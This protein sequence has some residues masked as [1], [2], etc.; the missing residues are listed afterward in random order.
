MFNEGINNIPEG[1]EKVQKANNIQDFQ[2]AIGYI[3]DYLLR[4]KY[5]VR[6]IHEVEGRAYFQPNEYSERDMKL[7]LEEA[8]RKVIDYFNNGIHK[9]FSTIN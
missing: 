4:R 6:Y 5:D 3:C 8:K 9:T 7:R 1:I 2:Q